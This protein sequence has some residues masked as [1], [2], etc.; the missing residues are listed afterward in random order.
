MNELDLSSFHVFVFLVHETDQRQFL[1]LNGRPVNI[2]VVSTLYTG[3]YCSSRGENALNW[4][5]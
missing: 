3:L 1:G 4:S 2:G 5:Q